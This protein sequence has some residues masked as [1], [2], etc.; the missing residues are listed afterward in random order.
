VH[1]PKLSKIIRETCAEFNLPYQ[2]YPKMRY[3]VAS[4]VAF[5]RQMGRA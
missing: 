2:E 4:H 3:A 1:Y 5:L